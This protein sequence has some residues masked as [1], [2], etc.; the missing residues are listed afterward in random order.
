MGCLLQSAYLLYF[1]GLHFILIATLR[2][3][4]IGN[5]QQTQRSIKDLFETEGPDAE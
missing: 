5:E 3:L 1:R 2:E 4:D